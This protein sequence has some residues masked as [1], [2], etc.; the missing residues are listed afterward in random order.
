MKQGLVHVWIRSVVLAIA[1]LLGPARSVTAATEGQTEQVHRPPRL[2]P[3]YSDVVIPPNI[4]PLNFVIQEPG[5]RYRVRIASVQGRPIEIAGKSATVVIPGRPWRELL[6]A[7]AGQP[8]LLEVSAQSREGRWQQFETVTNTISPDSID[9][10]L[11]YRLLRPAYN[12][13][14][15]IG[16][17]QREL[18]T[19]DE[20]P[21]LE[22]RSFEEGCL[23]CH[24]FLQHRPERMA[25]HIRH[26]ASGNPML[27]VC[28]NE[29]TQVAKTAGYLSWHPSGRLLAFSANRFALLYHTAGEETRELIDSNSDLGI[30]RV[31]SNLVVTPPSVA[32]PDRL[33]NWP[34]WSPDGRY[35]YFCSAPKLKMERFKQVRY[36]LM[37]VSYDLGQDQWGE[38]ETVVSAQETRL[39]A[40][41][42]RL[43]PDGRF[44]LFCL[45]PYGNFPAYFPSSDL[46]LM[47]LNTRQFRRLEINSD[48]CESWH[49]WSS[50][51]RWVVFSSKRRDGLFARPHFSHVDQQGRLSK[52]LLLPQKDPAFYDTCVKTFN[53]PELIQSPVSVTARDLAEGVL[54]PR[55]VLKPGSEAAAAAPSR[56]TEHDAVEGQSIR[57]NAGGGA[58]PE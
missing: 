10:Y 39:S 47:D 7:N 33:E 32:R 5:V 27:L 36:D 51:S 40:A 16:I 45:I 35:L 15:T 8:V 20:R 24:T 50:N 42:P 44:L 54:K 23:N 17:Y 1:C 57:E 56:P 13:Y 14:K 6:L 18:G 55:R 34:S 46:Y 48:E 21:L 2:F 49:C 31:D 19:Y 9:G 58:P 52:P 25:L 38:P 29:V 4:A 22:N 41:Q 26:K 3:E 12:V 53:L 28:S 30:Y 43:S 37:R 11:V